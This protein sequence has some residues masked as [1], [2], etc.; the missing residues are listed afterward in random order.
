MNKELTALLKTMLTMINGLL[1][2]TYIVGAT[3]VGVQ[4]YHMIF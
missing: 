4:L 1:A 3:W 2:L